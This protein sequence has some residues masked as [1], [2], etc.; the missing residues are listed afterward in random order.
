VVIDLLGLENVRGQILVALFRSARAF[1][2]RG[3][4]VFASKVLE[5]HAGTVRT[6]FEPVPPGPF[7]VSVHHDEDADY[8]MDTGMFGVPAEG[9]GFSRDARAPFGPPDFSAARLVLGEGELKQ[10]VIHLRY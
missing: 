4:G 5:P 9:Y 2:D 7:A 1:P 10:L 6:V 8:V 3:K